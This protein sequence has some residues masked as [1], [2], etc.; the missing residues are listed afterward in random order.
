MGV[1]CDDCVDYAQQ[2]ADEEDAVEDPDCPC[3]D[4]EEIRRIREA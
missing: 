2:I 4:C 3:D 1:F